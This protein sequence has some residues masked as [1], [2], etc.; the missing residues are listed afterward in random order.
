MTGLPQPY[1]TEIAKVPMRD[2]N[3]GPTI[4]NSPLFEAQWNFI[5]I[6]SILCLFHLQGKVLQG[7][8]PERVSVLQ[9]VTEW[10]RVLVC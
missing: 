1:P 6:S 10:L 5:N 2:Y 7:I 3:G 4:P 8:F 9:S